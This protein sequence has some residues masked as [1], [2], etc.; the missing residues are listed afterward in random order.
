MRLSRRRKVY[1]AFFVACGLVF[2]S[3][4]VVQAFVPQEQKAVQV[5]NGDAA[6]PR[7]GD[8]FSAIPMVLLTLPIAVVV[9]YVLEWRTAKNESKH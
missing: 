8:S 5:Q 9:A 3:L 6:A 4:F 1:L 2:L 7:S